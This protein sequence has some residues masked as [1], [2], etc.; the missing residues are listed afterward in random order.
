MPNTYTAG[1]LIQVQGVWTTLAGVPVNPTQVT[2]KYNI[3]VNGATSPPV[4]IGGGFSNPTI[5]TYQYDLDTTNQPG[6]WQYEWISTGIGQA[7]Q[8]GSFQVDPLPI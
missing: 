6:Y 1:D 5:G 3:T 4:T 7:A 2:L 8:A